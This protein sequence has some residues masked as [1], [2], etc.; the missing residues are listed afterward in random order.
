MNHR[1]LTSGDQ[2]S[3]PKITDSHSRSNAFKSDDRIRSHNKNPRDDPDISIGSREHMPPQTE[4][5][6]DLNDSMDKG[7]SGPHA[8]GRYDGQDSQVK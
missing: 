1:E 2:H 6:H 5:A 8:H 7:G 4:Q 3:R